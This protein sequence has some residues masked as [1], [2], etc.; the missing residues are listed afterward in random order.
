[1]NVRVWEVEMREVEVVVFAGG[2]GG[3]VD[4]GGEGVMV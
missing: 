1:M 3:G 2:E 4:C